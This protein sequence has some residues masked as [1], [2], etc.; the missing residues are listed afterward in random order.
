MRI[1]SH[2]LILA[3]LFVVAFRSASAQQLPGTAVPCAVTAPNGIVAGEPGAVSGQTEWQHASYG[4]A[5]LSV[6]PFG[7]WPEGTIVFKPGGAGSVT[8]DGALS[9]KFGWTRGVPGKLNVTGRRLDAEAPPLRIDIPCCYGATGFQA[10]ALIFSTPGCWEVTAQIGDRAD[11]KLTF[12]TRVVKISDEPGG[13]G[14][15]AAPS[16]QSPATRNQR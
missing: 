6:G 12:V 11:S 10:S 15:R 7:L 14:T 2:P 3:S 5:L 1:R 4:N 8:P 9:M 13:G 16:H